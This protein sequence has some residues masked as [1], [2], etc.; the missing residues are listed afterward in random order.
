MNPSS[1]QD[2][3]DLLGAFALD[4]VDDDERDV[5]EAHL[6]GC[7]R[8]RAEVATHRETAALLAHGGDR[9]P[10]G[11]WARITASL[12]ETPPDIDMP[13]MAASLDA[14][15]D[16][17]GRRSVSLRA[18]AAMGAVAAA[19][20]AFFGWRIGEQDQ[21]LQQ[22]AAELHDIAA[23]DGL[24]R[25]ATAALAEADAEQVRLASFD[26]K[27]G[28]HLVRLPNG[29]GFAVADGLPALPAGRTYQLWALRPDAKI[30]LGLLGQDPDVAPFQMVGD[31]LGYAIT[32]EVAGGVKETTQTPVVLGLID[33]GKTP[34]PGPTA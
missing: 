28:V 7:P 11:V 15:R 3:Q 34:D 2:I 12:E 6:V 23:K 26:G 14:A 29:T 4:A 30:S 8:C 31:V 32:D 16:R 9:A 13:P 27:T 33:P 24:R 10:E 18:A 17:R 19:L 20:T 22:V 21:R 1:H 25:A 5:I